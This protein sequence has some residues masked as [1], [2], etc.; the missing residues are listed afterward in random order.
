MASDLN[1]KREIQLLERKRRIEALLPLVR[2]QRRKRMLR[3]LVKLD[4]EL[5]SR[6]QTE[7]EALVRD[8]FSRAGVRGVGALWFQSQS[9]PGRGR[10]V[11]LPFYPTTV[12]GAAVAAVVTAAGPNLPST[13]N[14]VVLAL[15]P[16]AEVIGGFVF[17][18]PRISWADLR[19]ESLT[20]RTQTASAANGV[21]GVPS[22]ETLPIVL[23]KNLTVGGGANLLPQ[24]GYQDATVYSSRI[25]EFCGLRDN[26]IVESPNTISIQAAV[27]GGSTTAIQ[28]SITAICDVITDDVY[29]SPIVG[30]YAREGAQ[31]RSSHPDGGTFIT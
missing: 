18:A 19:L 8:P 27:I 3:A 23:V 28:F 15:L 13:T 2:D 6:S 7:P 21:G 22:G 29:G 26:P 10:L 12:P 25:P 30:P 31:V 16:V 24:A 14:P 4:A 9:P 17:T 1:P 20:V 11:R 5:E